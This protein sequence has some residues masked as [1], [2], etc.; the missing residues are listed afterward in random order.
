MGTFFLRLLRLLGQVFPGSTPPSSSE[1]RPRPHH[2]DR[3]LTVCPDLVELPP[4]PGV[5]GRWGDTVALG[6]IG[7]Q[8]VVIRRPACMRRRACI[9]L[10]LFLTSIDR[11]ALV[12]HLHHRG[13]TLLA[14][15]ACSLL[16]QAALQLCRTHNTMSPSD[17]L[18]VCILLDL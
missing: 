14:P 9:L 2:N 11:L 4:G 12:L 13:R 15:A 17:V 3:R 1:S 7:S 8:T 5:Q 6:G 10:D 18:P 16:R